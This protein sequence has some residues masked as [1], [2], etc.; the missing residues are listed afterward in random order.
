MNVKFIFYDDTGV[1]TDFKLIHSNALS[2]INNERWKEV[3][4][5]TSNRYIGLENAEQD[6][7]GRPR[8]RD[9]INDF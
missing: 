7:E 9:I 6:I 2:E 4:Y 1:G 5:Y 3:V 8:N